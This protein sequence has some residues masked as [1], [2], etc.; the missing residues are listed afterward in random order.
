MTQKEIISAYMREL[1]KRGGAKT[2]DLYGKNHFKRIGDIARN[3]K[4]STGKPLAVKN[5]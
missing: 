1:G 5:E 2:K 3:K 4:L